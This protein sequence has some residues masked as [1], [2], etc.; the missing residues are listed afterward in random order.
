VLLRPALKITDRVRTSTRLAGLSILLLIPGIVATWA[1]AA[2]NGGQI[3]FARSE[4][5]GVQALR[6]V[7]TELVAAAGGAAPDS[8]GL[9]SMAARLPDLK[10]TDAV[11]E[12]QAAGS[13]VTKRTDALVNLV[14]V[15]GNNSKLIL[16]PD[17]DSFYIMDAQIVQLPKAVQAASNAA[18]PQSGPVSERVAA[19][20][21]TA[22]GLSG[23]ATALH[24]DVTTA[25]QNTALPQLKQR[26]AA[27]DTLADTV[28]RLGS[29]LSRSLDRPAAADPRP[30]LLAAGAAIGPATQTLMTLLQNR[31][32]HLVDRRNLDLGVTLA[33]FLIGIWLAAAV[34]WRTRG[35]V[36]LT[37]SGMQA[38]AEG[39]LVEL[40]LPV[41]R[42]EFGDVGRS[43]AVAREQ[44]AVAAA[45][46]A[47][48]AKAREEQMH[49]TFLQ[50]R[51]AERQSRVRAQGVVSET[52][53]VVVNELEAVVGHV[54]AVRATA[55]TIDSRVA[56]ANE[57]TRVVVQQTEQADRVVTALG[58]S[59]QRV[60]SM[61]HLIAGIADQTRLL[62]LNATIEAARAGDAGRGFS[63]VA[64]EVKNLAMTTG[65]STSHITSIIAEIER[66]AG[67]MSTTMVGMS[68]GIAGINEANAV[69]AGVADEQRALVERLDRSVSDTIG[70]VQEMER[71]GETLERRGNE[72]VPA[73]GPISVTVEGQKYQGKLID[74]SEAGLGCQLNGSV[75]F[76]EGAHVGVVAQ[77]PG[78]ELVVETRAVRM[79]SN[80]SGT[81]LGVAFLTLGV[82]ANRLVQD[83]IDSQIGVGAK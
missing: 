4:Q 53:T 2:V 58:E 57:V 22:G 51:A 63:V 12:V 15:I 46:L 26:A 37:V 72:R 24:T 3:G 40:P 19:Q 59:L 43:V 30:V 41:G 9:T 73:H 42:D 34:W 82:E 78:G 50:Q 38:I 66:D 14:T 55:G 5:S 65:E 83:T 69:L 80:P 49:S 16:D 39:N 1:F 7:L 27:L 67:E 62:A 36:T 79:N 11:D 81:V 8:A 52:S 21:V 29:Q 44:L 13:D 77:L 23:A 71:L 61:A 18:H 54:N 20:A 33:F 17:L 70:R 47:D 32:D 28:D 68:S 35:D 56:H 25:A 76:A 75:T 60:A 31:T 64:D 10:L 74:I 45:T 6:P 48:A